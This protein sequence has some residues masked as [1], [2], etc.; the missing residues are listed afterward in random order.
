MLKAT[1]EQTSSVT[2]ENN[3]QVQCE[4]SVPAKTG[5]LYLLAL[6]VT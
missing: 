5:F 1:P 3:V 4:L 6:P 2:A